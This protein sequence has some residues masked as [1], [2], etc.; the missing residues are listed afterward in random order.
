MLPDEKTITRICPRDRNAFVLRRSVD[1]HELGLA[2]TKINKPICAARIAGALDY[3]L[4]REEQSSRHLRGIALIAGDE[5]SALIT[6]PLR[7]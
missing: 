6:L 4:M 7:R 2:V 1:L 5:S 3:A